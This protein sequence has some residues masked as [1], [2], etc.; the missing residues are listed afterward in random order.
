MRKKNYKLQNETLDILTQPNETYTGKDIPQTI[1]TTAGI[2]VQSGQ[3]IKIYKPKANPKS[4]KNIYF[5]TIKKF[6]TLFN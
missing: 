6:I 4:K 2:Y 1:T 3:T 5:I